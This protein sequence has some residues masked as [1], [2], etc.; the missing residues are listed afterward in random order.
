MVE[1]FET[2]WELPQCETQRDKVNKYCW[3]NVTNRLTNGTNGLREL[4]QFLICKKK[5]QKKKQNARICEAQYSQ[6][7][8]HMGF[9]GGSVVKRQPA[10]AR[11][12]RRPAGSIPGSGR[13]P[14]GWDSNPLQDSCL[15]NS[16]NKEPSGLQSMGSQRVKPDWVTKQCLYTDTCFYFEKTQPRVTVLT[17]AFKNKWKHSG[18]GGTHKL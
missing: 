3:K 9:P 14:G 6:V 4:P 15:E 2:L 10:N 1:K 16:M 8:L 12:R 13:S 18:K 7:C 5:K 17:T 11:R